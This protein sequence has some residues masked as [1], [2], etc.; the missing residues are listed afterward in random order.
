MDR[1][2]S[3]L[4]SIQL[5]QYSTLP[6]FFQGEADRSVVQLAPLDVEGLAGTTASTYA[7][8]CGL[9]RQGTD[10]PA[11]GPAS[12]AS[13]CR[14]KPRGH[15]FLDNGIL[16][17]YCTITAGLMVFR[18]DQTVNAQAQNDGGVA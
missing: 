2:E 13:P 10:S 14:K 16:V 9:P 5:L 12:A 3:G 11:G 15:F 8:N 4:R 1:V 7:P 6:A 17:Y 18:N